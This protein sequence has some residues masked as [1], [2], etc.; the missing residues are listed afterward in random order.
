MT[1]SNIRRT[2]LANGVRLATERMPH[3]RS[4]A[5]GIWL[6]RGSRHEPPHHSG[7]A[8]FV[9]HMLFK[10]TP[11]QECGRNR[12]AGRFDRRP[13]RRV[14]V[15]GIRG[16]LPQGPRRAPA[17]RRRHPCGSD[18]Q[19]AVR[20]RRHRARKEGDPRRDQDG[21]GHARRSGPRDLRRRLLEQSSARPP[22]PR[23]AGK[24]SA[25]SIR[26]RCKRLFR[27]DL[28][29]VELRRRRGRQSRALARAG[30]AGA[31]APNAPHKGSETPSSRRRSS[32]RRSRFA[33]R[34][35]SKATSCSAPKPCR[36]I[37]PIATRATR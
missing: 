9:E 19:S 14:H 32:R 16:L 18:L 8:H 33:R 29:G 23:H 4:V 15:E 34:S 25:R 35:S 37:I 28:R 30:P 26:R 21:R 3:V 10:G 22:D 36:S 7:I 20:G 24:A 13:D 17:A 11:G 5:V 1:E 27:R 12:A 2:V 6:T 31:G